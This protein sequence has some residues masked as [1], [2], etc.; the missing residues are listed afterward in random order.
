MEKL[1]KASIWYVVLL[2]VLFSI[3][4]CNSQ[5]IIDGSRYDVIGAQGIPQA[6]A[7]VDTRPDSMQIIIGGD[8]KRKLYKND[9]ASHLITYEDNPFYAYAYGEFDSILNIKIEG[10]MNE[11]AFCNKCDKVIQDYDESDKRFCQCHL[12][13]VYKDIPMKRWNRDEW[14][15]YCDDKERK[16]FEAGY[17]AGIKAALN[18]EC[19]NELFEKYK[20]ER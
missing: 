14:L 2:I 11:I 3:Q 9:I 16:A 6:P 7:I 15:K 1:V 17:K 4:W 13:T 8:Y 5:V 19:P 12:P 18:W 10:F 20:K